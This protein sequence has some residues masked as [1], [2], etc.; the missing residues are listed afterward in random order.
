MAFTTLVETEMLARHL[1]D[2]A[3]AILDCRFKIE[4]VT[5][6]EREYSTRHIPGAKCRIVFSIWGH[7]APMNPYDIPAMD[8]V[9]HEPIAD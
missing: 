2:P 3:F 7:T 6:G 5:W 8:S 1:T 9:L 4:D